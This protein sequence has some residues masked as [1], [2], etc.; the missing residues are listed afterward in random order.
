MLESTLWMQDISK[1]KFKSIWILRHMRR[2]WFMLGLM[3]CWL[4]WI[5]CLRIGV[6]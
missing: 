1:V 4:R 3:V 5:A 2:L 6:V